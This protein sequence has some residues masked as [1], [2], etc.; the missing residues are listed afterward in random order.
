[1]PEKQEKNIR[2]QESHPRTANT[3]PNKKMQKYGDYCS[4]KE[5]ST[6]LYIEDCNNIL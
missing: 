3:R 2:N 5:C 6:Y 4:L 1:V